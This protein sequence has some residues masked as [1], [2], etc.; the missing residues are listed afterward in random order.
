MP[1]AEASPCVGGKADAVAASTPPG[2]ERSVC[3]RYGRRIAAAP[4]IFAEGLGVPHTGKSAPRIDVFLTNAGPTVQQVANGD[5]IHYFEADVRLVRGRGG[6]ETPPAPT[7]FASRERQPPL[8]TKHKK[9]A[10]K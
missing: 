2:G 8:P 10:K 7:T 6:G 5:A 3:G 1:V 9:V 4:W